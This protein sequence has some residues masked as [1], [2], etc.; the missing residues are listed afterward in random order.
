[1]RISLE[2]TSDRISPYCARACAKS[3]RSPT[4]ASTLCL[5]VDAIRVAVAGTMYG[6][7]R[8]LTRGSVRSGASADVTAAWN[9]GSAYVN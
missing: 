9:A 6:V 4:T 2:C 3:M 5:S 7:D 1:M 8:P